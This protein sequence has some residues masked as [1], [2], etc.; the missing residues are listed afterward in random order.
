[1]R[2]ELSDEVGA[3]AS[4]VRE[5]GRAPSPPPRPQVTGLTVANE[6]VLMA[7]KGC[8][9]ARNERQTSEV[10]VGSVL[11]AANLWGGQPSLPPSPPPPP[12]LQS[13]NDLYFFLM[14]LHAKEALGIIRA[15][16]VG[17]LAAEQQQ[18]LEHSGSRETVL[19]ALG[20]KDAF[21]EACRVTAPLW[22]DRA[23]LE[24]LLQPPHAFV[25]LTAIILEPN[26]HEALQ[27]R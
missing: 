16:G 1:M 26:A 22:V 14:F 5:Q 10:S 4:Q 3:G 18:R 17:L 15:H 11:R 2:N 24:E 9:P 12:S 21:A 8:L 25:S 6:Y 13:R 19:A 23:K 20:A 27:H 7:L